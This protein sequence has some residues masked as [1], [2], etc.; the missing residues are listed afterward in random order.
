M[1]LAVG[2]KLG[3]YEIL[4]PLGAGGMGEVYRARDTK[5]DR[6]VAIK[7]LPDALAHNPERLA[8]FEREAKVLASL[9]HPNIAQIYGVEDRALVMEL[10]EGET[11]VRSLPLETALDY[12]RQIAEALEVAHD[13]GITHRDLKPANVKVTPQG[14]VKVLDFGLAAVAQAPDAGS[15][16]RANSPT[17]TIGVTE[18]GMIMGTAGYMSPEQAAGKPVDRRADIWSFGVLL[19]ELLTA[20]RLFD[21]ETVSHTLADVLRAPIDFDKLPR[22]TP[23]KIRD[24]LRRCL[25]RNAKKRLR[26]IGEARIAIEEALSGGPRETEAVRVAA[27]QPRHLVPWAVAAVLGMALVAL[28]AWFW[29]AT[30]PVER[31]LVRLDVDLGPDVALP[32]LNRGSRNVILSPDGAR[33]VY[34]SGEPARLYTRRLDQS[35]ANELPG[36]EEAVRP[37]FSPDGQWVGFFTDR[38]GN[39]LSKISVEGGAVVLVADLPAGSIGGSW[40]ADG[41][42]IVGGVNMGLLRVPASGGAPTTVLE[43]PSGAGEYVFPQILP[44]GKAVLFSARTRDANTNSIEVFSFADRRQ[45]TVVRGGYSGRYLPS[46][47]LVYANKGTL[48]AIP[49]D[50]DRLETRGTALPVLDDVAYD[51]GNGGVDV[52]FD[53]TGTLVYRRGSAAAGTI[54]LSI[55][56]VDGAGK[57]EPLRAKP[58]AYRSLRLSPDGKRMSLV[59]VEG[60]SDVWVYDP[61]RDAMTRLTFGAGTY[62]N[63][64]WSPDGRYVVFSAQ[65]GGIYW[66]RADGAGQPQLLTQS[67]NPQV[68][69]SFTPDGKRLAYFEVLGRPQIW[70]LPLEDQGGQW[71]AGKP[72]QFLK[73]QSTDLNPEFSPDGRWLAYVSNES[74]RNE[75]YVRAFPPPASGQGGKWQ[76]SNGGGTVARWSRNG[77]ELIY[78]AGEQVMAVTYSVNGDSFVPEKPRVWIEKLAGTSSNSFDL[79]PD[80]KRVLVL[81]PPGTPEAPKTVH[82][83]TFLLNFFDELR[84]RVPTGK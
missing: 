22:E 34:V 63:P 2:D 7:I 55:Q 77:R 43:R 60:R 4:A 71:K 49:F 19:W 14:V 38:G 72:E 70:T 33:L 29:R 68:P 13:K 25:D 81:T 10:V 1:S 39:K 18:T 80:G 44:G 54:G 64:I 24:L 41:N 16:S 20:E 15:D 8:R 23:A 31:P 50:V 27:P 78:L 3:P 51:P 37:F 45:K 26:D 5:L 30:R 65:G 35:K 76:V 57:K 62:Y 66:T 67:K 47:H 9:N 58:G 59:G 12:A 84:R 73:S 36:T 75:V 69:S 61:E 83:V 79:A 11:L 40:G 32:S 53:G 82:E 46:G 52:D 56:W 6:E 28:G 48:F 17:L 42:I 74:G 21:G